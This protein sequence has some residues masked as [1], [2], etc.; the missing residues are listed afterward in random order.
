MK[1]TFGLHLDGQRCQQPVNSLGSITV[2]P[3]G[4]LGIL[5]TQLGLLR[6]E[7]STAERTVQYQ[8]CLAECDQ[9]TRFYHASFGTDALGTSATLLNW[10]DSWYLHGWTGSFST[11][12]SQRL[13]DLAEVER[14]ASERVAP[15]IGQRLADIAKALQEIS[16]NI[17]SVTIVDALDAFPP[18]WQVVLSRLGGIRTAQIRPVV[19]NGTMLGRLQ[20]A[21]QALQAGERPTEQEWLD[22]GSVRVVRAE[23]RQVAGEWLAHTWL[24]PGSN[25]LVVASVEASRLDSLLVAG[26]QPRQGFGNVSILRPGLQILPMALSLMWE[27]VDYPCL[28]Q[29]LTDPLCPLPGFARFRLAEKL[30]S[31]PGIGGDAWDKTLD[32][33]DEHYE[34]GK[35]SVREAIKR[36]VDHDRAPAQA[37]IELDGIIQRV[38]ALRASQAR[39]VSNGSSAEDVVRI[40]VQA[41]CQALSRALHELRRQGHAEL[42][43]VQLQQLLTQATSGGSGNVLLSTQVGAP[44]GITHP[45]A[46]IDHFDRVLWWHLAAPALPAA[47]SWSAA[48]RNELERNN[49]P[50]PSQDCLLERAVQEWLQPVWSACKELL[51]VLPPAGEEL[52]PLWLMVMALFKGIPVHELESCL[53]RPENGMSPVEYRALPRPKRWWT[54]SEPIPSTD[55]PSSFSSLEQMLFNPY[56]W[57]LKYPARLRGSRILSISDDFQLFGNLAHAVVENLFMLSNV[58]DLSDES[59][60]ANI[61]LFFNDIV[62]DQGAVLL[63]PGRRAELESFRLKLHRAVVELRQQIARAGFKHVEP[64][65][66]LEGNFVGGALVGYADLALKKPDGTRAVIDMKWAGTSKYT[67]KLAESRHLQLSIYGELTRQKSKQWPSVAY[68]IFDSARLLCPDSE[69]FPGGR[70]V[71]VKNGENLPMLWQRFLRTWAWRR[72]QIE[73]GEIEVVLES[74]DPTDESVAPEDGL[75]ME[76]LNPNYNEYL[77]LAGVEE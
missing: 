35:K 40:T 38:D 11:S 57:L 1:I 14:L 54:L 51:L 59:F 17:E 48:E 20:A 66:R 69:G 65:V 23:T 62:A 55:R 68:Y 39:H 30:A 42:G 21:L 70:A 60:S 31:Q 56:H 32:V 28:I 73:K 19:N 77:A 24:Q 22:D 71:T 37:T 7:V 16:S 25:D 6:R 72:A 36:W 58:M 9:E 63:M 67:A 52:H 47:Y 15:S 75:I 8:R 4:M 10:R 64:E 18:M 2:G 44:L 46:A 45:G 5:E 76:I 43:R 13:A 12:I 53:I 27:P 26:G 74:L 34:D 50:F 49:V 3:L 61:E 41:H 33:L 29:F